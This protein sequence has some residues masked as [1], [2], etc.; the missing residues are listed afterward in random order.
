M[1]YSIEL[2]QLHKKGK[3][4]MPFKK[5]EKAVIPPRHWILVGYPGSGKS[6]FSTQMRGPLLP[7]DADH[8]Y[9]EVA[10]LV[11]GDV[12]ELSGDPADAVSPEA[13][14]RLLNQ[15]MPGSGTRTIIVDSL[16]TIIVPKVT[17][18]I[19]ESDARRER[20]KEK[21]KGEK[22][23]NLIAP[24]RDK[25]L[26]MRLLQ[27]AVTK[28][29][30]DTLWIYHLQDA[31]DEDANK[32]TKPILSDT[33]RARLYRSVNM[34]LHIVSETPS[35]RPQAQ[36]N[37]RRGIKVIWA[38][39]G[40]SGMTLWDDSG[41]WIGMPEKI[42]Q[43][44]YGGLSVAD[45]D[46]IQQEAPAVFPT[47]EAAIEWA[48]GTYPNLFKNINHG[49]NAFNLIKK[50]LPGKGLA[51]W[52]LAWV[53]DVDRRA[54]SGQKEGVPGQPPIE[55]TPVE[56]A[57]QA[58]PAEDGA[59]EESFDFLMF[60][61]RVKREIKFFELAEEKADEEIAATLKALGVEYDSANE[62]HLLDVLNAHTKSLPAFET[63]EAFQATLKQDF[64]LEKAEAMAKVKAL[65]FT[66]FPTDKN[67]LKALKTQRMYWAV[68]LSMT[69]PAEAVEQPV[70]EIP[71]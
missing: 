8:R 24:F 42:E 31:R 57:L 29:G 30:T 3:L 40:R 14:Y 26:A 59:P 34:E 43:A 54:D 37:K 55:P 70:D 33:E 51:E 50:A 56:Q 47:E 45:Q 15:N 66:G 7:I 4:T 46:K 58:G 19:L 18:A 22:R 9:Q 53:E 63:L 61:G 28:W 39:R 67:G 65:G 27:D 6:T 32:V 48:L 35:V 36:E 1:I 52:S 21:A 11:Q 60:C 20:N 68:K 49:R 71:F 64:K 62:T 2:M 10:Y 13:I 12:Y 69:E 16:T 44:V 17:E 5:M 23:E 38:R 41:K 25:A